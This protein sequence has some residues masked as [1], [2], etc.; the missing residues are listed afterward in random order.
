MG[1]FLDQKI[2]D[3]FR[4]FSSS[5]INL[6]WACW[7]NLEGGGGWQKKPKKNLARSPFCP[8]DGSKN[9]AARSLD[10]AAKKKKLLVLLS[11]TF[12]RFDVSLTPFFLVSNALC[13]K[14]HTF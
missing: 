7:P 13:M 6:I 11:T 4:F 14:T 1:S 2:Y 9:N 12:E 3:I 8:G 5:F 10:K